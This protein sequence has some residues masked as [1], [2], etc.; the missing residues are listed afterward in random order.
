MFLGAFPDL[1]ITVE[2]MLAED[3][4]VATRVTMRGTHHG[5]LAGVAPTGKAVV[6]KANHIF[7][8][9]RMDRSRNV[10]VRWTGWN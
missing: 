4:R 10:T 7:R 9:G 2:D 5:P 3:D 1:A 6:M 8:C